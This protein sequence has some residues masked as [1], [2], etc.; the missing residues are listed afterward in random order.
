MSMTK[1]ALLSLV[2]CQ[3]PGADDE[4]GNDRSSDEG[5]DAISQDAEMLVID[6]LMRDTRRAAKVVKRQ[7]R[8]HLNQHRGKSSILERYGFK[9]EAYEGN[10]SADAARQTRDRRSS[11]RQSKSN[12]LGD[13][14]DGDAPGEAV[15]A[16]RADD[17][18][19]EERERARDDGLVGSESA[20]HDSLLEARATE[21]EVESVPRWLWFAGVFMLFGAGLGAGLRVR[22]KGGANAVSELAHD[23]HA[24]EARKPEARAGAGL[25][26]TMLMW[27]YSRHSNTSRATISSR[28][29][30]MALVYDSL[31]HMKEATR[32]SS[33]KWCELPTT[34]RVSV[35]DLRPYRA[36]DDGDTH[37]VVGVSVRGP[38]HFKAG[39]PCQDVHRCVTLS[40]GTVIVALADG[41]GSAEHS[42][43]GA[44]VAVD[45]AVEYLARKLD[46]HPG[47]VD[48]A[49]RDVLTVARERVIEFGTAALVRTSVL[50]STLLV[51]LVRGSDIHTAHAG[52]GAIVKFDGELWAI[53][54]KPEDTLYANYVTPLASDGAE[55]TWR[56]SQHEGVAAVALFSDGIERAAIKRIGDTY[57]VNA[58]FFGPMYEAL[59]EAASAEAGAQLLAQTLDGL[60][61]RA[62]NDDDKS[63][64]MVWTQRTA[65]SKP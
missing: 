26:P 14:A 27:P 53:A 61:L 4:T 13:P 55:K 48:G 25:L 8:S 23:G 46:S 38:G 62:A 40:D 12:T 42:D 7:Q 22:S 31:T 41:L 20:D 50:G 57:E 54:S 59:T 11:T 32:R 6:D 36:H 58:G 63:L 47:G 43:I 65:G 24:P 39:V 49:M 1:T 64:V 52:D 60:R 30:K 15:D 29:G 56:W 9:P 44:R 34:G 51:V 5:D 35:N 28:G 37:S 19:G 3:S 2:L 18:I 10:A 21:T 16:A 17:V 33:R 45:A